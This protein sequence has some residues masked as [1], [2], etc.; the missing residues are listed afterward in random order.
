MERTLYDLSDEEYEDYEKNPDDY[1]DVTDA[2]IED[3]MD[4]MFG[5]EY[6]DDQNMKKTQSKEIEVNMQLDLNIEN[7]IKPE[8]VAKTSDMLK[9]NKE[10]I[11]FT[12]LKKRILVLFD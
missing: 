11:F 4:M 6:P 12:L 5:D 7:N 3:S 2:T 9:D 1:Q 10:Q 8:L